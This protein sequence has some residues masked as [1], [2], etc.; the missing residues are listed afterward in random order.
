MEHY[1]TAIS[2][3]PHDPE[4]HYNLGVVLARSGQSS[5]AMAEL[6]KALDLQPNHVRAK[7]ALERLQRSGRTKTH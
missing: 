5:K 2:L 6:R 4:A 7:V 1:R 3:D